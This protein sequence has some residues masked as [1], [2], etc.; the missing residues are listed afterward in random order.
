MMSF[1]YICFRVY[2]SYAIYRCHFLLEVWGVAITLITG[3]GRWRGESLVDILK[4]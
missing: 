2:L 3:V 4:L 1:V